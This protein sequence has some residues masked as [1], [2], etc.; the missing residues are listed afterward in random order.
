MST[1]SWYEEC[2]SP[3]HGFIVQQHLHFYQASR[4]NSCVASR[5]ILHTSSLSARCSRLTELHH[6]HDQ[7]RVPAQRPAPDC[8]GGSARDDWFLL[9]P[10]EHDAVGSW[11]H[12]GPGGA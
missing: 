12:Q 3:Q 2:V 6:P 7:V 5:D 10:S 9:S 1:M 4:W 8:H 11:R